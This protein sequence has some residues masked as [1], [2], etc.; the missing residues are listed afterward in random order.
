MGCFNFHFLHYL[1]SP[2]FLPTPG[3]YSF[4]FECVLKRNF[5]ENSQLKPSAEWLQAHGKLRQLIPN[6]FETRLPCIRD[7]K[8]KNLH[9]ASWPNSFCYISSFNFCL[10]KPA[11]LTPECNSVALPSRQVVS[12][13]FFP[14]SFLVFFSSLPNTYLFLIKKYV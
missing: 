3:N 10:E 11:Y 13:A 7:T 8:R 2:S 12:L 4:L 5:D 1:K 9:P 14:P 6:L